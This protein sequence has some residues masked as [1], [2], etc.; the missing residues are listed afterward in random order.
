MVGD[1]HRAYARG[2]SRVDA[3]RVARR[4]LVATQITL[5]ALTIWTRKAVLPTTAHVAVGAA[6]LATTVLLA[7]R[8]RRAAAAPQAATAFLATER[9]PA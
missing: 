1:A 5:G 2:G 8:A 9:V 3:T 4:G 6:I 7:A